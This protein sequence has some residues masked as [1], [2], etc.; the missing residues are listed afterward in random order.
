[1]LPLIGEIKC[2]FYL[3]SPHSLLPDCKIAVKCTDTENVQITTCDAMCRN[4][5]LFIAYLPFFLKNYASAHIR[6]MLKSAAP[7]PFASNLTDI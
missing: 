7:T 5:Y 4:E 3:F 6:D 2:I 1:M